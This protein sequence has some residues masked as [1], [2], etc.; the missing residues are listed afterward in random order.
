ML[1]SNEDLRKFRITEHYSRQI[2]YF[3]HDERIPDWVAV[4]GYAVVVGI[5]AS[6][7]EVAFPMI[8][9]VPAADVLDVV[10]VTNNAVVEIA[11]GFTPTQYEYPT[12]KPDSQSTETTGFQAK[13]WV[14]VMLK[15][16]STEEPVKVS[17]RY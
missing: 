2:W 11:L 9:Y 5:G 13:N 14:D 10:E 7:A 15:I 16:A 6:T 3:L 4:G 17:S 1:D 12:W 8:E